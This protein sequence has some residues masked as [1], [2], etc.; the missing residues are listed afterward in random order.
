MIRGSFS[1]TAMSS[2]R[3]PM[4]AGPM[5]RKRELA[6]S[7]FDERLIMRVSRRV[8][9]PCAVTDV[10]GRT[11]ARATAADRIERDRWERRTATKLRW[12]RY[13]ANLLASAAWG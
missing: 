3:P 4:L 11:V 8:A 6:S 13:P 2:M 7:G 12:A 5:E 9:L 10:A 1:Y